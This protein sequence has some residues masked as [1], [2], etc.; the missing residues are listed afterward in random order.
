[1]IILFVLFFLPMNKKCLL[2]LY[3]ASRTI[4]AWSCLDVFAIS[5]FVSIFVIGKMT[6]EPET[7]GFLNPL[8]KNYFDKREM[9]FSVDEKIDSG[10]IVLIFAAAFYVAATIWINVKAK[11]LYKYRVNNDDDDDSNASLSE[12]EKEEEKDND[13]DEEKLLDN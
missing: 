4:Y 2:F 6:V 3:Y 5:I 9:C 1:M 11:M 12:S 10:S 7:C 13:E 8:L